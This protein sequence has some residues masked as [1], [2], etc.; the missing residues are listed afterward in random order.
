MYATVV[1]KT[2]F[3]LRVDPSTLQRL[4]REAARRGEPKTKVAE[5]Y[6][7]EGVRMAQH[8]GVVFR[9]GRGGRRAALAGHR[10]DVWQVVETMLSENGDIEAA[11]EYLEISP[12]LASSAVDYYGQHKEEV[13]RWIAS[14]AA[15]AAEAEEAWR[16]RQAVAGG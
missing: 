16:R 14:N 3:S 8:P 2:H 7:E 9:D 12:G 13:D 6:L 5:R 1:R 15:I 4:E 11:A 10:L